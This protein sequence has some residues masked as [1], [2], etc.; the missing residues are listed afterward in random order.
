MRHHSAGLLALICLLG[1][2]RGRSAEY[3]D[4]APF[5]RAGTDVTDG[6]RST[7]VEWD[8]ER[9]VREIRVHYRSAPP[10]DIKIEYWF[11]NW[12]Y[13]HP[14]MPTME[15]PVDDPWQGKWLLARSDQECQASDCIYTFQPL[16]GNRKSPGEESSRHTLSQNAQNPPG[17]E[18]RRARDQCLPCRYS[19]KPG[20]RRGSYAWNL[21]GAKRT[22]RG[23]GL[24]RSSMAFSALCN[25]GDFSP[26]I[27]S[28][29]RAT[30]AF[31]QGAPAERVD[32]RPNSRRS[33]P[34]RLSR[35]DDR[36]GQSQ[37]GH[38]SW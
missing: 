14:R 19:R 4:L 10:P 16:C 26:A 31:A 37:C 11:R 15:D 20:R 24:S 9:D 27:H 6:F 17:L 12:P 35:R 18:N 28:K 32:S 13:P 5:G 21:D 3:L 36:H 29:V 1:A 33:G 34:A 25:R 30:G 38:S 22:L 8:D 7:V 23:L 2:T